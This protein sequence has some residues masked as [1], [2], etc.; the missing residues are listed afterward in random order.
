MPARKLEPSSRAGSKLVEKRRRRDNTSG[1]KVA[2]KI[3]ARTAEPRHTRQSYKIRPSLGPTLS[4]EAPRAIL[5]RT[6]VSSRTAYPGS[7]LL[8]SASIVCVLRSD[9]CNKSVRWNE[10]NISEG[11]EVRNRAQRVK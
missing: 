7:R 11:K 10:T 9:A 2:R 3:S 8:S 4:S 1:E 5:A 6:N